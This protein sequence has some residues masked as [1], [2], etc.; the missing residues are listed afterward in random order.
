MDDFVVLCRKQTEAPMRLIRRLMGR[1]GL[2][3]NEDKTRVVD[4]WRERI[5][6]L[7]FELGILFYPSS[8]RTTKISGGALCDV[9]W[10][11]WF[12]SVISL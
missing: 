9:H 7:G 2:S 5:R 8:G 10:I 3:L 6:F 11:F 12:A 4:V 1:M